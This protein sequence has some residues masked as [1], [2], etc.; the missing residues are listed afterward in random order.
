[1]K[2]PVS[3]LILSLLS[4]S[5][6]AKNLYVDAAASNCSDSTTYDAN[7]SSSPWCTLQ[8][9]TFG[10]DDW[11]TAVPTQAAKAGDTV[12]VAAGTYNVRG[13]GTRY[14]PAFLPINSGN[15]T[16]GYITFEAV[17]TVRLGLSSSDGPVIGSYAGRN[18]LKW[19]GFYLDEATAPYNPDT[20]LVA[21]YDVSHIV[22]EN[23]IIRALPALYPDNHNGIRFNNA[24]HSVVRGNIIYGLTGDGGS[25][26][27]AAIMLYASNDIVM[28]NNEIFESNVGIFAKGLDNYNITIRNNLIHDVRK[29]IRITYAHLTQGMN[30]VYQNVIRDSLGEGE[31]MGINIAENTANY[32]FDNNTI[33]NFANGIYFTNSTN[34]S[35]IHIRNNIITNTNTAINAWNANTKAFN[36]NNNVYYNN[37]IWA[38][39]GNTYSTITAWKSGIN[40]D[41]SADVHNPQFIDA[42]NDNFILASG[43]PSVNFGS[44]YLDYD[45]DSNTGENVNAGAY[46]SGSTYIG[47]PLGASIPSSPTNLRIEN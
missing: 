36:I 6:S 7:N 22:I 2:M 46:I 47:S 27:S 9:A 35:N 20:G 12:Y 4:F 42:S 1:M 23:C 16:D 19:K 18:Y 28:E 40:D 11:E 21:I 44:D 26:N 31:T 43:S 13:S 45:N 24:S 29:G 30:Y 39:A 41:A 10:A 8:R 32:V 33:D 3:V 38:Y 5:A 17:G 37:S 14:H 15:A 34:Q 25:H